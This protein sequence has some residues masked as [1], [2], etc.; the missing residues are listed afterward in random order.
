MNTELLLKVKEEILAEP[1]KLH[2]DTWLWDARDY[3]EVGEGVGVPEERMPPCKTVGCI[4]GWAVAASDPRPPSEVAE[5]ARMSFGFDDVAKRA[6]SLLGLKSRKL[7]HHDEEAAGFSHDF[8]PE[9]FTARL[10]KEISGTPG[11]ARVVA[12]VIDDLIANPADWG[13]E[14]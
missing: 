2:M 8:W 10:E 3:L 1:R 4:A 9:E 12:D 5:D 11:Y 6:Q 14:A 13:E 7:F